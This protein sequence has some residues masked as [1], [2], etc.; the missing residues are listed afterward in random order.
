LNDLQVHK[1]IAAVCTAASLAFELCEFILISEKAQFSSLEV[2]DVGPS[3]LAD[4]CFSISV[5]GLV[6]KFVTDSPGGF[7]GGR[8]F[9]ENKQDFIVV[10]HLIYA[11]ACFSELVEYFLMQFVMVDFSMSI[12]L[13][14]P[15]LHYQ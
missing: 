15:H 3:H 5:L 9:I 4:G 12:A 8:P 2:F 10:T 1:G 14:E 13:E 7:A 11:F 6:E